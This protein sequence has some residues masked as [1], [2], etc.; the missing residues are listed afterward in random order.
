AGQAPAT[1]AASNAPSVKIAQAAPSRKNGRKPYESQAVRAAGAVPARADSATMAPHEVAEGL[2]RL[3]QSRVSREQPVEN[4]ENFGLAEI[5]GMQL[6]QALPRAS[7]AEEQVI[8]ARRLADQRDLGDV[9]ARAAVR[10]AGHSEQNVI[11]LE[12]VALEQGF[13]LVEQ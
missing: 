10:A 8:A 11:V 12:T 4:L 9:G 13:D 1:N 2:A 3:A 6:V 5:L 7:T